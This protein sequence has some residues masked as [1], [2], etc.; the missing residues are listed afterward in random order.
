MGIKHK[1]GPCTPTTFLNRTTYMMTYLHLSFYNK[2]IGLV[3]DQIV[4]TKW[5]IPV[6]S[7]SASLLASLDSS[8]VQAKPGKWEVWKKFENQPPLYFKII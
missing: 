6:S 8:D 1:S 5:N 3:H 4:S 7:W 2:H